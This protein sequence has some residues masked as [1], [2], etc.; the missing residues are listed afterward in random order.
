MKKQDHITFNP[1]SEKE[2]E[3]EFAEINFN[4]PEQHIAKRNK[5]D[6]KP[7]EFYKQTPDVFPKKL[8]FESNSEFKILP[9]ESATSC[10][11]ATGH[12]SGNLSSYAQRLKKYKEENESMRLMLASNNFN[13]KGESSL[14]L[15]API[16]TENSEV[17][18]PI[19]NSSQ[20]GA[21]DDARP[22]SH[23]GDS[24]HETTVFSDASDQV[25]SIYRNI[26]RKSTEYLSLVQKPLGKADQL[27]T[28][29]NTGKQKTSKLQAENEKLKSQLGYEQAKSK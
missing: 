16:G 28:F 24:L 18:V 3:R 7:I 10:S 9:G 27:K 23:E 19:G 29:D 17:S 20:C 2:Q 6:S 11:P 26:K 14:V 1:S 4:L 15:Q 12:K 22:R 5:F 21:T 13:T 8:R 25:C